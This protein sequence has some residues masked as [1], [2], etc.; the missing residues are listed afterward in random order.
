MAHLLEVAG[1]Q[2]ICIE[3]LELAVKHGHQ[4]NGVGCRADGEGVDA[5]VFG[6]YR[7]AASVGG[8]AVQMGIAPPGGQVEELL[9][10]GLPGLSAA[11]TAVAA[12]AA[13]HIFLFGPEQAQ[14]ARFGVNGINIVIFIQ[15]VTQA[16]RA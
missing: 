8:Q 9:S 4:Q 10:P 12:H 6:H 5:A 15:T 14:A 7:V 11:V 16:L 2:V 1:G 3:L 13:V